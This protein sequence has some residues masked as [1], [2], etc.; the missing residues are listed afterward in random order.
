MENVNANTN[1]NATATATETAVASRNGNGTANPAAAGAA[2]AGVMARTA[3]EAGVYTGRKAAWEGTADAAG[4]C[5]AHGTEQEYPRRR[6][7]REQEE[8][9]EGVCPYFIRDRGRGVIYCE[10][11]RF[12]FPDKLA[13]REI[14]Y[15]YC[16]HPSGYKQCV[17]KQAMD[18]FYRR[19][20]DRLD[21]VPEGGEA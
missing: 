1:A 11:A 19:K 17:L 15:A 18:G 6:L 14:V 9:P 4:H 12:H 7:R 20:Y 3:A 16:A 8:A 13:R 2:T 5:R 10:C 21:A